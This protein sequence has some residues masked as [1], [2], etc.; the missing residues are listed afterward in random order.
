ML[1]SAAS[2]IILCSEVVCQQP[3][4]IATRR[5]V[6]DTHL[7]RNSAECPPRPFLVSDQLDPQGNE[8]APMPPDGLL[9]EVTLISTAGL[10]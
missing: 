10:S 1:T 3:A 7:F 5:G 2:Y 8:F 6:S 4:A 9:R